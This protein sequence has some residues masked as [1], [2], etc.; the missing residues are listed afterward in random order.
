MEK[1]PSKSIDFSYSFRPIYYFSRVCGMT[2]FSIVHDLN[3]DILNANVRKRDV[4]W[5]I[6][7]T[8]FCLSMGLYM[9]K[10]MK[11]S[12]D[13]N[14]PTDH[15]ILLLGAYILST[16]VLIFGVIFS[17]LDIWNRFKLVSILNMFNS[18]D[19]EASI[20]LSSEY[21]IRSKFQY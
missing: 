11:F 7:S 17:A 20:N 6:I 16:M 5:L 18:F 10:Y 3:G 9:L 14:K 1:V 13:L 8:L 19:K 15:G 2:P 21:S 4:V 12:Q